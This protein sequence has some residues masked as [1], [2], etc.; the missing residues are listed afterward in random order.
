MAQALVASQLAESLFA[1]RDS[2]RVTPDDGRAQ[3]LK[4]FVHA[5][6]SVHLIR[7]THGLDVVALDAAVGHD[8]L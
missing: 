4:V 6:Q 1:V 8:F 2:T 3:L 5:N 7:D